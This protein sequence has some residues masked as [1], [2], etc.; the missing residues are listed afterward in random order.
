M[1]TVAA[2]EGPLEDD[3]FSGRRKVP[4]GREPIVITFTEILSPGMLN[5]ERDRRDRK[6]KVKIDEMR[7]TGGVR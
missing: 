2:K 6:P 4:V 3:G 5:R 1:G 7:M